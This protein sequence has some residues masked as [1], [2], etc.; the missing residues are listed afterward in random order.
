MKCNQTQSTNLNTI[1][2][3][4]R[5][6]CEQYGYNDKLQNMFQKRSKMNMELDR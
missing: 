4:E 1:E 2:D 5:G 6:I 3:K